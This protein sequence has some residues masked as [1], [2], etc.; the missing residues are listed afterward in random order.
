MRLSRIVGTRAHVLPSRIDCRSATDLGCFSTISITR[1]NGDGGSVGCGRRCGRHCRRRCGR[2][3]GRIF[4][5]S[6]SG[7]KEP[8]GHAP[9][10]IPRTSDNLLANQAIASVRQADP[11]D[12]VAMR[13]ADMAHEG[14]AHGCKD[15]LPGA[16]HAHD[17]V[18]LRIRLEGERR[19]SGAIIQPLSHL[20]ARHAGHPS[21]EQAVGDGHFA[22]RETWA[23]MRDAANW[24]YV[25]EAGHNHRNPERLAGIFL[26]PFHDEHTTGHRPRLLDTES[27]V[28]AIDNA[29]EAHQ[30]AQGEPA[31]TAACKVAELE[32][33]AVR[34]VDDIRLAFVVFP[35]PKHR[36]GRHLRLPRPGHGEGALPRGGQTGRLLVVACVHRCVHVAGVSASRSQSGAQHGEGQE[37]LESHGGQHGRQT[38]TGIAK[39]MF[40]V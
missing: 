14:H 32:V 19:L 10:R 26:H 20:R 18:A 23:P 22:L 27:Y 8:E 16:H 5:R 6:S 39:T 11:H 30:V 31:T 1:D 36:Q 24:R 9:S 40:L 4:D 3:C 38:Q 7:P 25:R 35:A 33:V 34:G 13:V 21:A 2:R 12:R 28:L 15:R 37:R 17:K 29:L